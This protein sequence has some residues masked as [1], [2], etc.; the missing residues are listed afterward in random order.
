MSKGDPSPSRGFGAGSVVHPSAICAADVRGGVGCVIMEGASIGANTVLENHVVVHPQTRLGEGCIIQDGAVLGKTPLATGSA[1]SSPTCTQTFRPLQIGNHA[2]IGTRAIC[3]SHTTLRDAVWIA[4]QA[5]VRE[6]CEIAS[7]VRI[8]K[9]A[10]I[11]YEVSI[12]RGTRIQ[13]F[14][15]IGE[16]M[17]IEEEVFIGPHVT[18]V[19]DRDMTRAGFQVAPPRLR[20]RARI[21]GGVTLVPGITVGVDALVMAGSVVLHDV[22]DGAVVIGYPA[23]PTKPVTNRSEGKKLS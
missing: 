13:A 19:C 1:G 11:E 23:K 21:G 7:D 10:I 6:G 16:R 8:G 9:Q 15:L 12:G 5:I 20:R 4:D 14:T 3:Y 22:P 17:V 2:R 18:T